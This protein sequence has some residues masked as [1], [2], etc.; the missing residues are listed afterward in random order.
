[1]SALFFLQDTDRSRDKS[2][3]KKQGLSN[4]IVQENNIPLLFRFFSIQNLVLFASEVSKHFFPDLLRRLAGV[5]T[6]P[7]TFLLVKVGD[8]RSRLVVRLETLLESVGIVV[9]T[10]NKRL[11]GNVVLAGNLRG[12]KLDVVGAAR[13]RVHK[14]ASD[15]ADQ[16]VVLDLELDGVLD[17]LLASVKHLVQLLRLNHGTGEAVQDEAVLAISTVKVV[18][19]QVND[20]LVRD[21]T[22]SLHD[23]LGL[24][25]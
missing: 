23:L 9:R 7:D 14:T 10:L 12:S 6:P 1:M 20:E 8:G 4:E 2:K 15:T 13:G 21:E 5:K 16:E 24:E 3:H 18:L 22:A 25:T 11:S 19:D 17:R